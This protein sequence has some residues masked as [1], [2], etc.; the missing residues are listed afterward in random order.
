MT[1]V[2]YKT[3]RQEAFQVPKSFKT[4][5]GRQ[6]SF[7]TSAYK[8]PVS[9]KVFA[10]NGF[11]FHPI[12]HQ[13]VCVFCGVVFKNF[14][15]IDIEMEHRMESKA[16]C[17]KLISINK[18]RQNVNQIVTERTIQ[19]TKANLELKS[20]LQE[21]NEKLV[22]E[23]TTSNVKVLDLKSN[24]ETVNNELDASRDQVLL[25]EAQLETAT[26]KVLCKI[27]FLNELDTI[28]HPCG[29]I[30]CSECVIN[31]NFCFLCREPVHFKMP[32]FFS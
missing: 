2:Y 30:F 31:T 22:E 20:L 14:V 3:H 12:D 7:S 9:P 10:K 13:V 19:Q 18:K 28:C 25:L 8:W 4:T 29:H 26:E 32:L 17:K 24:L 21:A 16:P 5:K 1:T 23:Q 11:F 27:C 15:P 6:K